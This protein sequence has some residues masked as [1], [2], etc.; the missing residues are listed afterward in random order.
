M[1]YKSSKR[2]KR[3]KSDKRRSWLQTV[4]TFLV[5]LAAVLKVILEFVIWL[6]TK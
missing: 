3:R 6:S 5:G 4:G 2:K 1:K